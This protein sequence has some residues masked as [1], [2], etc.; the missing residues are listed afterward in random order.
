MACPRAQQRST[1]RAMT[2]SLVNVVWLYTECISWQWAISQPPV[3][4]PGES[5]L[6]HAPWTGAAEAN[7]E[8]MTATWD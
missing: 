5:T 4:S 3:E 6:V 1:L 7:D 2:A 8:G